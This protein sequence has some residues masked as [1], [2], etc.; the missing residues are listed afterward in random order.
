MAEERKL[1]GMTIQK[2]KPKNPMIIAYS[3]AL[4]AEGIEQGKNDK[5]LRDAIRRTIRKET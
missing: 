3:E 5:R 2:R 1:K 4:K